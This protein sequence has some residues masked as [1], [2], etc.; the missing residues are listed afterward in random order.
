MLTNTS[1]QYGLI[2]KAF[3]WATAFAMVALV[4]A[5]IYAQSLPDQTGQELL[6]KA[7]YFSLHKTLGLLVFFLALGR[8]LWAVFQPKPIDLHPDRRLTNL[9]AGLVHY[10]LYASLLI[11]PLTGW[12]HHAATQG[13]API[14]WPFGQSLPLVP[15]D[16]TVAEAFKGLHLHF[17]FVLFIALALHVAGA[18]KH[19][20]VDRDATLR[21]MLPGINVSPPFD[22]QA[23]ISKPASFLPYV[24]TL[25]LAGGICVAVLGASLGQFSIN[26]PIQS[27][28]N[29]EQGSALPASDGSHGS[30]GGAQNPN[31]WIVETGTLQLKVIQLSSEVEGVFDNWTATISFN[32]EPDQNGEF[33]QVKVDIDMNSLRLG[34]VTQEAL[35]PDML[36][37]AGFPTANFSGVIHRAPSAI[38]GAFE[39]RGQLTLRGQTRPLNLPF[40]LIIDDK[41]QASGLRATAT[42]Q[43]SIQRLDFGVGESFGD[44]SALGLFCGRCLYPDSDSPKAP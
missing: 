37:A 42:G 1:Y 16:V 19:H 34:T 31:A 4:V 36:D 33:G 15:K 10:L 23:V 44:G 26:H 29:Q 5:A 30:Q 8:I 35:R 27:Q 24:R 38:D 7:F 14:W 2:S 20:F 22:G 9:L 40:T 32:P 13:F 3:H 21:R 41:A 11:M 43:T 6:R 39:V 17:R 18:L 25:V 12:I 28:I